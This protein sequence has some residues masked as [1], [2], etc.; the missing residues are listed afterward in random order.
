LETAYSKVKVNA[1]VPGC[2]PP[3]PDE[4]DRANAQET[5]TVTEESSPDFTKKVGNGNKD[6][7]YS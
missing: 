4:K 1:L 6:E 3:L 2:E 7:L 5:I